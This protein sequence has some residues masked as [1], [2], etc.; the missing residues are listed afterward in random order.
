MAR[1]IRL[2]Q[3]LWAE[4]RH[5]AKVRAGKKAAENRLRRKRQ[6]LIVDHMPVARNIAHQVWHMF[7]HASPGVYGNKILLEDMESCAFVGLTEA[8]GRWDP[9]K[10]DFA[11]YCYFR[12]R[13]SII[14][15]NRRQAYRE[16]L[17]VSLDEMLG[18][19][20][21]SEDWRNDLEGEYASD[22]RPLQDA[23][24]AEREAADLVVQIIDRQLPNDERDVLRAALTGA[25]VSD[26]AR[27]CGQPSAW[28]R[29]KLLTARDRVALE[30]QRRAA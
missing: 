15:A 11:K 3:K 5:Q 16:L 26:I 4:Y 19:D 13:G 8:A 28:A 10:G 12:V 21:G 24:L 23:K 9:A 6:Q 27:A 14:D 20:H 18:E 29:M 2:S 30:V 22:P 17:H 7:R 1:V 25:T